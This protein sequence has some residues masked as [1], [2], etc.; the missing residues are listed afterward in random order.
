MSNI[1]QFE[2]I[3][4]TFT[5]GHSKINVL[6][7]VSFTVPRGSFTILFGPSGSGKSTILNTIVGL[8]PPTRGKVII[9]DVDLY[10]LSSDQR[11]RFRTHNV[12]IVTQ[13]NYWVNALSVLD[14]VAL[15]LYL[16]GE[17]RRSA[18]KKATRSIQQV[19]LER[20]L[21]S[22][23]TQL[24]GGEQQRISIARANAKEPQLLIADEP[25]GNL[26]SENGDIV[27]DLL[28]QQ[29]ENTHA[30]IVMVTHNPD[31]LQHAT[32]I[33]HIQDGVVRQ[34]QRSE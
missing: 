10:A 20:Y 5:S 19:K 6:K 9:S 25:T 1:I 26:D 18:R 4:K 34:E 16:S 8:E 23:P 7:N 29:I 11:A 22:H 2:N 31:F 15:P 12:G 21:N 13:D 14:N 32:N 3:E 24:S 30:T 28:K 17:R 33:L 27:I